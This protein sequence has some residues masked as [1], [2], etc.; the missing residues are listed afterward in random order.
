[1][2]VRS[3]ILT[4]AIILL[5]SSA[6]RAQPRI[7]F[8]P[9][10]GVTAGEVVHIGWQGLPEH[11]DEFELLLSI[12]PGELIRLT[13]ELSPSD[14][15]FRWSVPDL[16]SPEAVLVLRAGIEGEEVVLAVSALFAIRGGMR[17]AGVE[18]RDREWWLITLP[19][20][21][22]APP[23][24]HAIRH[25]RRTHAY[26]PPRVWVRRAGLVLVHKRPVD[27]H[28]SGATSIDTRSGAPLVVPRR[29]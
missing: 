27:A 2:R 15:S 22:A 25:A 4:A 9:G 20:P 1:M 28:R 19:A 17:S 24:V 18:F 8:A 7:V 11:V 13:P 3:W 12:A 10:D 26:H 6:A 23:A 5:C 16:P 14:G 21:A 29:I